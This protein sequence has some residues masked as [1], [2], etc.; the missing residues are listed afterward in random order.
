MSDGCFHFFLLDLSDPSA[1][2][3][4]RA[5]CPLKGKESA[6][7]ELRRLH[8]NNTQPHKLVIMRLPTGDLRAINPKGEIIKLKK[9][10]PPIKLGKYLP[11]SAA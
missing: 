11:P 4:T 2:T 9:D 5:H 8:A 1:P 7:K 6:Y 10:I 3:A